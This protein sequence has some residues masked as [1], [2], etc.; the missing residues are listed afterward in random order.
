MIKTV[1]TDSY[2]K[3]FTALVKSLDAYLKITD[4]EDHEFY[5]QYNSIDT[6]NHVI[7]AYKGDAFLG[8]GAI[9]RYNKDVVE[10][11]R[12]Y[13]KP[14]GRGLGIAT[15]VLKAL[16][17]C[18]KELGYKKC[19]LETGIRQVEAVNFYK[20]NEY[21]LISNYGQYANME[22]SLCFEIEV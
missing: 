22:E 13:V 11:K 5:N 14:N 19:I 12:M 15:K 3:N 10:I 9:K 18:A 21:K 6:L 7:V 16:E 17:V 1:R 20:K 2:D 8:C 4:G